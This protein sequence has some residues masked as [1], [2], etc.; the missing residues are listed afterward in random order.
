MEISIIGSNTELEIGKIIVI[1][2]FAFMQLRSIYNNKV[3]A[4]N[5]VKNILYRSLFIYIKTAIFLLNVA[6]TSFS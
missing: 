4:Y 6:V 1:C 2:H 5:I 3:L